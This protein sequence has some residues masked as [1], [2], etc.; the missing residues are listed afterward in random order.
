MRAYTVNWIQIK[1][2]CSFA[3]LVTISVQ[4]ARNTLNR[5][6]F[7][8]WTH[9]KWFTHQ[10]QGQAPYGQFITSLWHGKE[11]RTSI[12]DHASK[13]HTDMLSLLPNGFDF[14]VPNGT[15]E[16]MNIIPIL[17]A[18]LAFIKDLIGNCSSFFVF[19]MHSF[20]LLFLV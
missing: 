3:W 4:L 1:R 14:M 12:K 6:H 20:I 7:H 11:T 16:S 18:D 19:Y 10:K 17:C 5:F 13:Y 15:I 2:H 8:F 9:L